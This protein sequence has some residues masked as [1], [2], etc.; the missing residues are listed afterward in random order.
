MALT[1]V[2][3]WAGGRLALANT[4][5]KW[6]SRGTALC[7]R[8]AYRQ[9]TELVDHLRI[10][11][12]EAMIVCGDLNVT[13]DDPVLR[14]LTEAGML[15]AFPEREPTAVTNG[16]ARKIDYVFYSPNLVVR[17]RAVV[18]LTEASVVPSFDEPSD[19]VPLTVDVRVGQR[20]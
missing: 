13:P 17:P 15:E 4:H 5:I 9:L 14:I 11:A 6:D 10:L 20:G 18:A 3:S 2:L 19:H 16:R 1:L 8:W 12:C 7:E